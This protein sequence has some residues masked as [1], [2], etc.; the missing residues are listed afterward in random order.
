MGLFK[1]LKQ[2]LVQ[3]QYADDFDSMDRQIDY[4]DAEVK[5]QKLQGNNS[6]AEEIAAE[7]MAIWRNKRIKELR[8]VQDRATK[9]VNGD[10]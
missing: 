9:R 5:I 2:E 1:W 3:S 7:S 10:W 6:K 4:L 8:W